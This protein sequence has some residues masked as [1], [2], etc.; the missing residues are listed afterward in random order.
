MKKVCIVRWLAVSQSLGLGSA[1]AIKRT[2]CWGPFPL[3]RNSILENRPW[4]GS[5]KV[6]SW[7]AEGAGDTRWKSRQQL[8]APK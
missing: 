3:L 6:Y 4:T 2:G 1:V 7:S 5:S 8:K